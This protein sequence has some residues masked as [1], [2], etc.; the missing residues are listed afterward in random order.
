[1]KVA[2]TDFKQQA[3]K[4]ANSGRFTHEPIVSRKAVSCTEH[5]RHSTSHKLNIT[6]RHSKQEIR[7]PFKTKHR[8]LEK[9]VTPLPARERAY[10]MK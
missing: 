8:H 10:K 6:E 2:L 3:G 5:G 4:D 7:R 9:E 1:M